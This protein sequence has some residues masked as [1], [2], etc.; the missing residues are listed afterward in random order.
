MRPSSPTSTGPAAA[1]PPPGRWWALAF[2]VCTLLGLGESLRSYLVPSSPTNPLSLARSL[3]LGFGLWY[4]WGL[5][6]LFA[7]PL[8]RRFPLGGGGWRGRLALHAAAC[9]AFAAAKIVL[10]YPV[11]KYFYCPAPERLPFALFLRSA[12]AGQFYGYVLYCWAM[13]GVAHALDYYGKYREREL[14]AARLEAGL[15]RAQLQLLKTQLQPHFLFNALN[16]V[17][18]LV[19]TDPEGADR[20]LATLGDLLR[21]T[22]EDFG[23]QEAPL[24]RELELARAYLEIE[25]VRLGP[26]LRIRLDV[27]PDATDAYVPTFLLQ[28]LIENAI[29]HGVAPRPEPGRVEVRVHRERELLRLEV[30]DDGPGLPARPAGGGGVG[31]ANTRARLFHLYG[32]AQRL[33]MGNDP[34]GGCKV[35]VT[36]PFRAQ[37]GGPLANGNGHD[38]P[39]PD[40]G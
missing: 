27:A 14:H 17:S 9:L 21:R 39:H 1:T 12:F 35:T 36:L 16:A 40:R 22:L 24:A 20:M 19:H 10:D 32:A 5:L 15:A 3:G 30:R 34:R 7:F 38:D 23:V 25:Q 26:R 13:T 4:A 29:R 18:A 11:I 31:L 2:A 8:A 6:W 28:P 33:E 37:E